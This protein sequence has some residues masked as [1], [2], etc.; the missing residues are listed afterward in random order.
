MILWR[1]C[2]LVASASTIAILSM[3]FE[4]VLARLSGYTRLV[5]E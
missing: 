5:S 1:T 4:F 3:G 2:N